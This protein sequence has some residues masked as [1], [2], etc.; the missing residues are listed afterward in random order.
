MPG[1]WTLFMSGRFSTADIV[2]WAEAA[3]ATYFPLLS[4][5][6]GFWM[7]I[8]YRMDSNSIGACI[9]FKLNSTEWVS[10][11]NRSI[12]FLHVNTINSLFSL[13][14]CKHSSS[15]HI[16][17]QNM[18]HCPY[19]L[20]PK[21]YIVHSRPLRI[22]PS[23][24]LRT[25]RLLGFNLINSTFLLHCPHHTLQLRLSTLPRVLEC[26]CMYVQCTWCE[27]YRGRPSQ[28]CGE[29]TGGGRRVE[30]EH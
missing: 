27:R 5:I 13:S 12:S 22:Q 24:M 17:V 16:G 4:S 6:H 20:S 2:F 7:L 23:N 9:W 19:L 26:Q 29:Y 11:M 18:L 10:L 28:S 14:F 15:W 1:V 3:Y 30:V 21:K 8:A 25:R